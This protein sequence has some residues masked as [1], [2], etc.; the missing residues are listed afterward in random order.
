[1]QACGVEDLVSRVL[2]RG[3]QIRG[4]YIAGDLFKTLFGE[5]GGGGDGRSRGGRCR[6]F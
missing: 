4:T 5:G 3:D 2:G 6:H 1:M